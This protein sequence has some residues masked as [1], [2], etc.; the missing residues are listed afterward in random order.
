MAGIASMAN[1]SDRPAA[2]ARSR[3]AVHLD[4]F[5]MDLALLTRHN[6][7]W[8][9]STISYLNASVSRHR[10]WWPVPARAVTSLCAERGFLAT[11]VRSNEFTCAAAL[12]AKKEG[13]TNG[14]ALNVF[15]MMSGQNLP[16]SVTP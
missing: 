4:V 13:G 3:L 7:W 12:R 16:R 11:A 14:P 1:D 8:E 6:F 5:F 10:G 2:L 15:K 9:S